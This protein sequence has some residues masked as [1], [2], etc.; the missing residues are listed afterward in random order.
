MST[1][2]TISTCLRRLALSRCVNHQSDSSSAPFHN[3]SSTRSYAARS[4]YPR[5]N[6]FSRISPLGSPGIRVAPIIDQWVEEGKKVR[7]MELKH[8]LRDL[9]KR[10][11]FTQA[12]EVSEWMTA[13]ENFEVS[14]SDIAV[15]LDL[16]GRVH[17]IDA[18]ESYFNK[19]D[20]TDKSEKVYGALLNCYVREGLVEKSMSHLETMKENGIPRT[21]LAYNDLMCLYT[22]IGQPE[23]VADVMEEMRSNGISPDCFSYR[24]CINSYG[25]RSDI[26]SMERVVKEMEGDPHVP[27]DW[28]TYAV[29]ANYLIKAGLK[30]KGLAYLKK[31]EEKVSNDIL[32]FNHLISLYANLES[33]SEMMRL[34]KL[35]KTV[36]Q[37][38]LNREYITM[39]GCLVKLGELDDAEELLKQWE[40]T[41]KSYDFRVPN[42]LLIGYCQRGMVEKAEARLRAIMKKRTPT[43]NSWAILAAAYIDSENMDKAVRCMKEALAVEGENKGWRPKPKVM[44]TLLNWLVD[45]G[46]VEDLE[47]FVD[48]IKSKMPADEEIADALNKA[49]TRSGKEVDGLLET[50]A[51]VQSRPQ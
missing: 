29:S 43:P 24:M 35:Q 17:G 31:A 33:K 47:D 5:N 13:R 10:R 2:S 32:G 25:V 20:E 23:K 28:N 9:R 14:E 30:E 26:E 39:L 37:R 18:A 21:R 46:T 7:D 42:I 34:W 12:L 1:R 8:I 36:C 27:M 38:Q 22:N 40:S 15:Q 44:T 16:I 19:V 48:A 50:L 6:L 51:Y 4:S 3:I 11:R 41:C 49:H 45:N